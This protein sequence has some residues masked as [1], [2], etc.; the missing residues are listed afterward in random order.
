MKLLLPIYFLFN[1]WGLFAQHPELEQVLK[2]HDVSFLINNHVTSHNPAIHGWEKF[3]QAQSPIGRFTFPEVMAMQ[4]GEVY[5][6]EDKGL[7]IQHTTTTQEWLPWIF[8]TENSQI[9]VR[10]TVGKDIFMCELSSKADKNIAV[11]EMTSFTDFFYRYKKDIAM[12]F[13]K[14]NNRFIF[15][16]KDYCLLVSFK[17]CTDLMMCQNSQPMLR[18]FQGFN[19]VEIVDKSVIGCWNRN[20]ISYLGATF[21]DTLTITMEV[22]KNTEA[23]YLPEF[24]SLVA[25]GKKYWNDFFNNQVPPLKTKNKVIT[26]TYY[27]AWVTFWSN[28]MEGGDGLAPYPYM[29]SSAFMYPNQFFWDEFFHSILLTD[30]NDPELPYLFIRNFNIAQAP[31]GGMPG[32]CSITQDFEKYYKEVTEQGSNDMQPIAVA[33]TMK[34]LKDKPGWTKD[35]IKVMYEMYDK[36]VLWLYKSKDKNKNGLVEYTNSFNSGADDSP[37]FD[38]LYPGGNHIG[39]MEAVEGLEQNVWLSLMHYNLSE[40]ATMLGDPKA[41]KAHKQKASNLEEKIEKYMWNEADGMYYDIN[42]V[43]QKQIKVKSAFTFMAM[44]L[45]NARKDRIERL[46]KEHLTNPKEFWT[47]YPVPSVALSESTFTQGTMW[48]G[49]VWPN[50][51]WLICLGLEQ[52]GFKNIAKELAGKTVEMMGPQYEGD[53]CTRGPRFNEWFNPIT[54]EAYGNENMSWGCGAADLI[55]RFLDE[56]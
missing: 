38:G 47:N 21:K 51:N 10:R 14:Q 36:Y 2:S 44:F 39:L 46:V 26:E 22:T 28:Y 45:K 41:S 25:A 5:S 1:V 40:M 32:G 35:K 30:L 7:I 17:G 43:T 20:G 6:L 55:L 12:Q 42:T 33:V 37:R 4:S 18:K 8:K 53:V 54:G 3:T 49:P 52:Q 50:I 15:T 16:W 56:E 48:R 27:H 13:D 19:D 9:K 31:D 29:A 34:Y 11:L 23:P 24:D